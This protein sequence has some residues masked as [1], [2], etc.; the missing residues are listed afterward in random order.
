MD[1]YLV[2]KF[3]S[4]IPKFASVTIERCSLFEAKISNNDQE[5]SSLDNDNIEID[6][7]RNSDDP[8]N[9]QFIATVKNFPRGNF[10]DIK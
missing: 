10:K 9:I 5:E 3:E 1:K 6:F 4:K 2:E 8:N 7:E